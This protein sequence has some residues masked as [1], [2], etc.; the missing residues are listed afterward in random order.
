MT[1][2]L[3]THSYDGKIIPTNLKEKLETASFLS[4]EEKKRRG[5]ALLNYAFS[6]NARH[7]LQGIIDDISRPQNYDPTNQLRA[8]DLLCLCYEFR[9]N[10]D[11]NKELEIQL[12]DMKTGFCPQ[13]RTHRLYQLLQAFS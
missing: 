10:E 9:Q 11:F 3:N 5:E 4:L 13:G 7:Y 12:L 1:E 2:K 8:D 6:E